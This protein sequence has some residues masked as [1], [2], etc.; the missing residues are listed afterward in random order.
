VL[1]L[2]GRYRESP[3]SLGELL[4]SAPGGERV[5]LRQVARV[6]TGRGPEVISRE[7]G[8]RRIVVQSNVRGRDLGSFAAEA[9]ER[10]AAA[11]DLPPG[12][13]I[14]WGG[15]F[16]NQQRAMRRFFIVDPRRC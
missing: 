11:I 1:R 9:Q 8:Q 10:I 5:A 3:Q 16:E 7:D 15:Q 12:Y 14:D 2:P 13:F 4:L 6:E